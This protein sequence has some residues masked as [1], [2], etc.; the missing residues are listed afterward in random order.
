[1]TLSKAS[2]RM[3]P[4]GRLKLDPLAATNNVMPAEDFALDSRFHGNDNLSA[5]CFRMD[6]DST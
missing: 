6:N 5:S 3:L 2:Q 1:M 4:D